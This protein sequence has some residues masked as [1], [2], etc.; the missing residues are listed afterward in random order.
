MMDVK[1]NTIRPLFVL[2]AIY[3]AIQLIAFVALCTQLGVDATVTTF[4]KVFL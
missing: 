2:F 3:L 1:L 4:L